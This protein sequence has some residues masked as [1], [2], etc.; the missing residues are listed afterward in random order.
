MEQQYFKKWLKY[1]TFC[2]R[3]SSTPPSVRQHSQKLL[4]PFTLLIVLP[5]GVAVRGFAHVS[6]QWCRAVE[7]VP[8]D[9]K[10]TQSSISILVL[11]LFQLAAMKNGN[12]F[13]LNFFSF[14]FEITGSIESKLWK[15]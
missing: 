9:S 10:R 6:C 7:P 2:R 11:W 12:V 1:H 4:P 15:A 3:Y 13:I 14:I 8:Y 5:S